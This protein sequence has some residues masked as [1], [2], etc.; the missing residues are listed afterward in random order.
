ML[1]EC[2]IGV[3]GIFFGFLLKVLIGMIVG[4]IGVFVGILVEVVF[5]CMIVDGWFLVD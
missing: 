2:L 1:F 5:I 3:D 4:V